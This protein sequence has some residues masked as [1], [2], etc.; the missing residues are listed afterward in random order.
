[1][2]SIP[3]V[4]RLRGSGRRAPAREA[5]ADGAESGEVVHV[6]GQRRHLGHRHLGVQR[7][8]AVAG[9]L[10]TLEYLHALGVQA[11]QTGRQLVYRRLF[12][13]L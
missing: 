6:A 7:G 13:R 11:Q 12:G 5:V 10:L 2:P 4:T 1:M 9:A 8:E 3:P